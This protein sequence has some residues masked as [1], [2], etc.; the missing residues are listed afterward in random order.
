MIFG[1]LGKID[2]IMVENM[3]EYGPKDDNAGTLGESS[4]NSTRIIVAPLL[5]KN[6]ATI[7]VISLDPLALDMEG[8]PHHLLILLLPL[9]FLFL[10]HHHH[11]HHHAIH[12]SPLEE[13][14][15]YNSTL[16]YMV[17]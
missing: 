8:G 4:K 5:A 7:L 15:L 12:P 10:L 3:T 1:T 11:H 16:R 17:L 14:G 6:L 13:L 9:L 2:L